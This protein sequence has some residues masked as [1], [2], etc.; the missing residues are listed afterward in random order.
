MDYL[1]QALKIK[2]RYSDWGQTGKL[3]YMITD[4]YNF[5]LAW[6]DD[7]EVLF[8]YVKG[9]M[10][11]LAA[12][13]K[14]L[15]Q[16]QKVAGLPLVL[17]LDRIDAR[18]KQQLINAGISF[19]VPKQQIYLPVLGAVLQERYTKEYSAN[20]T[21]MPSSELLLLY[22]ITNRCKPLYM[23]DATCRLGFS[24][25]TISR[26]IR[27]LEAAGLILTYKEGVNKI[28]TSEL[29]GKELFEKAQALLSSPVRKA[30]YVDINDKADDLL[31]SGYSALSKYSLL[32]PP[33]VRCFAAARIPAWAGGISDSL[34]DSENQLRFEVWIYD[35]Q[36][37]AIDNKVGLLP[38]A[39]SLQ[40]D[41]DDRVQMALTEALEE[42]WEEYDG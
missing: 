29:R 30:V 12:L 23:H 40:D 5:R 32:N 2:V 35:P 27:Q 28:I 18:R 3:P 25:M 22:Y 15:A 33:Q 21:L 8:T 10:E 13:K 20:D 39:L 17:I 4:R 11:Q 6:L 7:Y 24:A 38:L 31:L 16:I 19:V 36:I 41:P 42:Y 9:E 14:H 26:A 37:L 34:L 1:E